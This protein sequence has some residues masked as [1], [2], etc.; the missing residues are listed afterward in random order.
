MFWNKLSL[1]IAISLSSVSLIISQSF[2]DIQ[3]VNIPSGT[4]SMGEQ[5]SEYQG[6][7]G[8]YDAT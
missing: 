3:F 8:S 6:P 2:S 4:F 1:L 5:E 7:P